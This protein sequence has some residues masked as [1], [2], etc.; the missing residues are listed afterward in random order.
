[1]STF[2]T[3]DE[4]HTPPRAVRT[5][6]AFRAA[7]ISRNEV[8]PADW[9]SRMIGRILVAN[10]SAAARLAACALI[11]ASA[12]RGLPSLAPLAFF[13]ASAALVRCGDQRALFFG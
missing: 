5:P 3:E 9:I 12:A 7:A 4:P 2:R 1:M 8:R 10:W 13:A 6:R 11:A